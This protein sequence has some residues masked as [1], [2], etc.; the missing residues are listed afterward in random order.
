MTGIRH[1]FT[2]LKDDGADAALVRPSD[3]NDAHDLSG[4]DLTDFP[5]V[6]TDTEMRLAPDGAGGVTWVTG[7]GVDLSSVIGVGSGAT[8]V[9]SGTAT[10]ASPLQISAPGG[11][12]SGDLILLAVTTTNATPNASGPT[13]TG[14]V[15]LV[16]FDTSSA[17]WE[18]AYMKIATGGETTF[19]L[20]S[21]ASTNAMAAVVF[22]GV[23]AVHSFA[24]A[25]DSL[26]S[27]WLI[28][29]RE[30]LQVIVYF[31]TA[32][33]TIYVPKGDAFR[34]DAY[35]NNGGTYS[36][37]VLIMHRDTHASFDAPSFTAIGSSGTYSGALGIVFWNRILTITLDAVITT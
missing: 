24:F 33:G 27:P 37:Q 11:I 16:R 22:R 4:V 34:T 2:S 23:N 36:E 8:V 25:A 7:G 5:T 20:T 9:G 30:G 15:E 29:H 21:S 12:A 31:Q 35:A 10:G 19:E 32:A 13:G 14:W 6:E 3:W 18:A 26:T 28:G 1:A 17:E